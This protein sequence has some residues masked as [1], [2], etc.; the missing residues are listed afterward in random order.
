MLLGPM[1]MV[2]WGLGFVLL[3]GLVG[4]SYLDVCALFCLISTAYVLFVVY[5]FLLCLYFANRFIGLCCLTFSVG[6]G[7]AYLIFS[8][9]CI[10]FGFLVVLLVLIVVWFRLFVFYKFTYYLGL[11]ADCVSSLLVFRGNFVC[12]LV[13][14][15]DL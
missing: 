3:F 4:T 9:C 7:C 14:L 15:I 13:I 12:I 5:L 2:V 6:F 11:F 10:L 1:N 8:I